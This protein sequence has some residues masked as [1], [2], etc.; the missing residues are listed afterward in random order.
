MPLTAQTIEK[1]T[2]IMGGGDRVL[3]EKTDLLSYAYD[4][5]F[6]HFAP[7][8]VCQVKRVEEVAEIIKLANKE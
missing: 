7:D 3:T 4:A 5:S 1:I 6:G 8:V 2:R